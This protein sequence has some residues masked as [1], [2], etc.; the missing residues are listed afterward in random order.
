MSKYNLVQVG[1]NC[2]RYQRTGD[3]L[4]DVELYISPELCKK[5]E[6]GAIKQLIDA[7]TLPG[8]YKKVV[9]MPDIH[10]G[11]GLPIGG[12]MASDGEIGVISAGAVGMD[13]NC[14]VRLLQSPIPVNAVSKRTLEKLV[15]AI[16]E[17]VPVGVGQKNKLGFKSKDFNAILTQGIDY[18]FK[19]GLAVATDLEHTEERG[20]FA[21]ANP[22]AVSK[23]ARERGFYQLGTLGGG[24]HFIEIGY[25]DTIYDQKRADRYGLKKGNIT[26][27]IHTG[28]RAFGHQ[29]CTDYSKEMLKEAERLGIRLPSKGLAA[30]PIHSK[31]GQRY[32]QAMAAAINFAFANRQIITHLIREIFA[33]FFGGQHTLTLIYD[34]AHN[35][36]KFETHFGRKV[37][38]HRK[39]ATRALPAKDPA[40]PS[41]YQDVGHPAIIPGSMGNPSYVMVGLCGIEET[42][43]SINH[44]A[45]RVLSRR[46]A[47]RQISTDDLKKK[48]GNVVINTPKFKKILDEAP[49]AYK[50]IDQ[51]VM[52]M[53]DTGKAKRV[54]RHRPLAVIKGED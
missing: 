36:A 11:F 44:G 29:I 53:E 24:N 39:G 6:S 43:K 8:V 42:F 41:C 5:V 35:I 30:V 21:G 15:K 25:I 54:A 40:N 18:L 28:S 17:Q 23:T 22:D 4:V 47:R 16:V 37:L 7:A 49:Q 13:I 3:M 27:L 51:V 12:I 38:V 50:D 10:E 9:G 32:Y 33:D 48:I 46:A 52:A 2:F 31:C 20:Y 45:G 34:V 19:K 26:V 1:K 14:G